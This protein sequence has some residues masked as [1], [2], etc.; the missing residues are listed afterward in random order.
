RPMK[1]TICLAE[2]RV[3]CEPSLKLL[4][5]SLNTHCSGAAVNLFYPPAKEEFIEWVKKCPQVQLQRNPLKNGHGWNIKPQV[6]I[7][8]IDKGFEEVI[9]I[10]SDI[11]VNRNLFPNLS[12]LKSD[13]FV[14]TENTLAEERWDPN[15]LRA[16][17]WRLPVGRVLPF[18][19][20]SGVLRVTKDHY[21]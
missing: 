2:D 19:L 3:T 13:T 20:N 18:A 1:S 15:A 11:I 12:A 17:L 10:D 5:L 7:Q 6:I 14:A 16:R 9:W 21:G 4:L 8:M